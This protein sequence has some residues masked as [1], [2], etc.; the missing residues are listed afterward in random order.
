MGDFQAGRESFSTA[1]PNVEEEVP[2]RGPENQ[3]ALERKLIA[4]PTRESTGVS[5]EEKAEL[6]LLIQHMQES[7]IDAV[8]RLDLIRGLAGNPYERYKQAQATIRWGRPAF[9]LMKAEGLDIDKVT[10]GE[11]D[12]EM[13]LERLIEIRR[14][15]Q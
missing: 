9:V 15:L 11:L 2:G 8:K 5:P 12:Q 7:G 4:M 14:R 13:S 3:I 6:D 10:I 1:K